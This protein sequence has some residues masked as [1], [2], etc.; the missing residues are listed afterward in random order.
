MG[1]NA[2]GNPD[3]QT[4][5]GYTGSIVVYERFVCMIPETVPLEAAGPIMCAGVTLY[6]PMKHWGCLN[7][8]KPKTVGIIGIGG[9]G[10]MGIKIAKAAG[11]RVVAIST[12]IGKEALAKEKGA[13]AFVVSTYPE[14]M[15]KE[16]AKCDL[17]L[18]TIS[19]NH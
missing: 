14:S 7:K 1:K 18:N 15:K 2:G 17:I 3:C 4:W 9:L 5:G 19:A 8:E 6:D 13:D 16:F 11:N 10:T 12:S